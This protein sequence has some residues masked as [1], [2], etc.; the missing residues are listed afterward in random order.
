M[1]RF[2]MLNNK[3]C[4]AFKGDCFSKSGFY[5]FGNTKVIKDWNIFFVELHYILTIGS[6]KFDV[7]PDFSKH[8][9]IVDIDVVKAG[10]E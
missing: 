9:L 2:G 8:I 10:I 7:V 1:K 4:T 5:L 6:Y 3:I